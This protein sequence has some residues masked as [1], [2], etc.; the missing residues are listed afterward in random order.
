[1]LRT[2]GDDLLLAV[3][4]KPRAARARVAGERADRLL[5]EVTAPALE[6]R[7]NQAACRLLA[8]HL[9]V[10]AGRVRVVSGEHHR[11]KL[12]RIEGV[13]LSEAARLLGIP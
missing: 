3:R 12:V 8:K 11:D 9:S 4:V 2:E 1:M 10:A 13:A 6:G 5:V 7:A